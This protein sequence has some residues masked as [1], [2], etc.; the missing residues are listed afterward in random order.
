MTKLILLGA[1]GHCESIIDV[2]ESLP[3][4]KIHGV[5][6]PSFEKDKNHH[7]L[8]YQILGD[9]D[10]I[11]EFIASGFEFVITVGQIKSAKIRKKLFE[12]VRNKNGKLPVIIAKNAYVSKHSVIGEGT[13]VMNYSMINSNSF[14][15]KAN[16]INTFANI[17]HGCV[18]GNFNHI[19]TRATVNGGVHIGN[20]VFVGSGT[21]IN[22]TVSIKDNIIIGSGS[23]VRKD[24]NSN[25]L[26]FGNPLK[27]I[28][29]SKHE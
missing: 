19:S 4:Y 24:L 6:D 5:L 7:V 28:N 27:V 18:I 29:K 13:V 14:I 12:L 26:A 17:E 20:E 15:G 3:D 16:I 2:I 10:R 25:S 11:G 1:G 8:G 21:I 23:N 22:E 9:D